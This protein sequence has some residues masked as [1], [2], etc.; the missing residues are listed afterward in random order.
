MLCVDKGIKVYLSQN[1]GFRIKSIK[2]LSQRKSEHLNRPFKSYP[3]YI[4]E[5]GEQ[6]SRNPE[7]NTIHNQHICAICRRPEVASDVLSD[8]NVKAIHG[9]LLVNFMIASSSS[10]PYILL[11]QRRRR[12]RWRTPTIALNANDIVFL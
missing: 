3:V 9:Y 4:F 10:F 5:F 6:A 1:S 2:R 11:R 8:E 7:L 12:R